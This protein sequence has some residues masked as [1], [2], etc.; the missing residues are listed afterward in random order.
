MKRPTGFRL[1][2]LP[3]LTV[4]SNW[5]TPWISFS[6][7]LSERYVVI[8]VTSWK[9][10]GRRSILGRGR[11]YCL[12]PQDQTSS[13]YRPGS[14][15]TD[16]WR[17]FSGS[18]AI[19]AW[20][21]PLTATKRRNLECVELLDIFHISVHLNGIVLRHKV[22][23]I[24]ALINNTY[25]GQFKKKVTLSH[26]H[27]EVTS[28]PTLTRYKFVCNWRGKV[29]QAAAARGDHVANTSPRQ[30]QTNFESFPNNCC[31]SRDCRLTGY[32]IINMCKSY[33]LFEL[34]CMCL[35]MF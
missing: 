20:N 3:L 13:G 25:T 34:P 21:R 31:I 14:C 30:L 11:N 5:K 12:S 28:E 1:E 19:E 9:L 15:L 10:Y 27:N 7:R 6:T 16:M 35:L 2:T 18:E 4:L 26:V 8:K 17:S 32:F 23:F 24:Y 22:N 29:F 33:L